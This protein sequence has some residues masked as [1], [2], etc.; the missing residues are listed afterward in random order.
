MAAPPLVR[1]ELECLWAGVCR[2][3]R[4][5]TQVSLSGNVTR[6]EEGSEE[7]WPALVEGTG[8]ASP[9]S[10]SNGRGV[11]SELWGSWV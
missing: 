9:S 7:D 6:S 5:F 11:R 10:G 3:S 2:S 8:G 4:Q 1:W